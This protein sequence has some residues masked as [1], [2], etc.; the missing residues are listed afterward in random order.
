V[1][2]VLCSTFGDF[3]RWAKV[4]G[5]PLHAELKLASRFKFQQGEPADYV[6]II[7]SRAQAKP[8]VLSLTA[9]KE[10]DEEAWTEGA[11]LSSVCGL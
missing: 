3:G 4:L 1:T 2:A 11:C 9:H 8:P 10:K 7:Y 6:S 5:S